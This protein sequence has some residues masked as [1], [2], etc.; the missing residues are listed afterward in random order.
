MPLR[1]CCGVEKAMSRGG[2]F[3]GLRDLGIEVLSGL[4]SVFLEGNVLDQNSNLRI[5]TSAGLG[6]YPDI[7]HLNRREIES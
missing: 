4:E 3:E 1:A 6:R 7:A 5:Q 2:Y